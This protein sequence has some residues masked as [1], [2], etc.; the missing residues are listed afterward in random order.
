MPVEGG[1]EPPVLDKETRWLWTIAGQFLCFVDAEAKP[2]AT[3][4]RLDL[5]T[6][7]IPSWRSWKR[8]RCS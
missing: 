2:H 7:E 3:L 4:N 6:G 1:A 8:I 5:S